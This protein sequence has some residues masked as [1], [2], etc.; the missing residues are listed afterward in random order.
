MVPLSVL[1]LGSDPV[2]RMLALR[3]ARDHP[4]ARVGM[5]G[6]AATDAQ[7]E[8]L[9]RESDRVRSD[10]PSVPPPTAALPRTLAWTG[11]PPFAMDAERESFLVRA[12][13]DNEPVEP[14]R[15]RELI[16]TAPPM[17][18]LLE[19][20]LDWP[21]T[22][23]AVTGL[24]AEACGISPVPST[25][26]RWHPVEG[27]RRIRDLDFGLE[28]DGRGDPGR[29]NVH[30]AGR[31]AAGPADYVDPGAL[32]DRLDPGEPP[33]GDSF[34]DPEPTQEDLAM[35]E[36]FVDTKTD[37]LRELIGRAVRTEN[38]PENLV[39]ALEGLAGEID[40][41]ARFRREPRLQRLHGKA[42]TAMNFVRPFLMDRREAAP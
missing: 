13:R 1:V 37:R 8:R 34:E 3:L 30:V 38:P 31:A 26:L 2:G 20:G 22:D 7:L 41:Y 19:S 10:S 23:S 36:G 5:M 21:G 6:R 12:A 17:L 27:T 32:L 14:V 9:R 39:P 35:P 11:P 18:D 25:E 33:P 4:D 42:L 40:S 15:A 16:V 28:C 29:R 24:V